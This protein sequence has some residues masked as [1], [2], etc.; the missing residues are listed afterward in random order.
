MDRSAGSDRVEVH[1]V[2]G[3][4]VPLTLLTVVSSFLFIHFHNVH[5]TPFNPCSSYEEWMEALSVTAS[6]LS[7]QDVYLLRAFF[8]KPF[9]KFFKHLVNCSIFDKFCVFH[10]VTD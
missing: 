2:A 9:P 5:T 6:V 8:S 1:E 4:G 7:E 3:V 10:G